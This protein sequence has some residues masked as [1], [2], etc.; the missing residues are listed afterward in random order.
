VQTAGRRLVTRAEGL[1]ELKLDP[2]AEFTKRTRS[3]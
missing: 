3:L 1:Q 2:G